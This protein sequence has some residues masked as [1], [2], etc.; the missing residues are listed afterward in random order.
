LIRTFG[1]LSLEVAS[2]LA[3]LILVMSGVFLSS[4]DDGEGTKFFRKPAEKAERMGRI[5]SDDDIS[6]RYLN[7]A[8]A[9]RTQADVLK[10]KKRAA[11]KAR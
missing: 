10:V 1:V 5:V 9:Y 4:Q 7:M 11:K 3:P 6:Q 8:R 2:K